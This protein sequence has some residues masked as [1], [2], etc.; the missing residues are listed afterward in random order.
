MLRDPT[1]R[2][3]SLYLLN[4]KYEPN[5]TFR[6][7]VLEAMNLPGERRYPIPLDGGRYATHLRRFLEIFPRNQ[8]RIYLYE[9]YRTDARAV[10]RDIF[11]FLGVNA[12]HPIDMSRRYNETMVL[13]LPGLDRLSQ[14]LVGNAFVPGWLPTPVS[15]ALNSFSNRPKDRF[16]LD[17]ADRQLVI[18]YY[19]DEILR[20]QDLIDRDLSAWLC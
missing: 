14:R 18:E 4:L 7:W 20:T 12:D 16:A 15:H 8:V 13:R 3:F 5:L 11:G 2:L 6:D 19:R 10:L 1:E 9:S 17:P